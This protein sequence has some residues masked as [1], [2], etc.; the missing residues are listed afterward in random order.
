MRASGLW[1]VGWGAA[2]IA[3]AAAPETPEGPTRTSFG[4]TP[5]GEPVELFSLSRGGVEATLTPYGA[6]IVSLTVPDRAGRRAD[7]V[8]GFDALEGYLGEHPFFGSIVGRYANRIRGGRFTLG[9]VEYTLARNDGENHLHG[10]VRNFGNVLWKARELATPSGPVLELSY[11]SPDGEEGYP[12]ELATRV[13]YS[14]TEA[15][16]LRIDY[17][18]SSSKDTIVNLSGHSYFNLA[19]QG[20]GDILAHELWIDADR[21]TPVGPGLIP[22]GELRNVDGTPFDFRKPVAIGARIGDADPQLV[23]GKGYDH[24]FV[25][26]GTAGELRPAARVR[27][28]RTGRVLE[29]LTTEPGLQ[30]YSGNFLDGTLRGKGGRQYPRRSGLCLEPQRFPDSPNQPGFPSAVLKRGERYRS[31]T[32]YRFATDKR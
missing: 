9:G 20:D 11:L 23:L 7:I 5:Q 19:G 8:L 2:V 1:I 14:V 30:F 16:E 15:G 32:V 27:D 6:T 29:L 13:S 4:R 25:L 31:T 18:A 28:P 17:E 21:F 24:N 26:N 10:G 22:T 3:A 12:G